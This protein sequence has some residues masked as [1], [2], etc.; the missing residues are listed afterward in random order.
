MD[1]QSL[2]NLFATT[3]NPDPNVQKAGE[4]QIRKISGQEG[5]VTALLQIIAS[6]SVDLAIRQACSVFIKNR[7]QTSYIIDPSRPRPDQLPIAPSDRDAL[8]SSILRLLAASPSRSITVQLASTL[9]NLVAH[10]VP[11]R[12]PGL[13]DEVKGLL[14]SGD[15]REV[16]AGCVAALEIV[17]AFRF[18]QKQD[19]LPSIVEQLMPT[20]VHIASGMMNTPPSTSQEIPTML[21]LIL[22]TYKSSIIVNLSTHQQSG[23]SL[24]PWGR[25]LFQVVNLQIPKEVVPGDEEDRERSEWWKAKKWAYGIL[26]R[27]FHRFGNPSQLPTPMQEEYGPFATHFVTTFAPE[28]FKVYL[29]QVELYVSGQAWLSK[30][31]QYQIFQFFTECVKPKTTWTLLKP[32]FETLVSSFVFPQLSFNSSK[33]QLWENDPVE[34]IRTSVDEYE[35][36]SSPVSAATSFLFS[37]SSNRTKTTFMPILGF[38][39]TVLRSGAAPAQRFGALNMTAALGPFIMR[40]PEV[41]DNMEQFMLQHVLPEFSAPEPYLRAI[42]CEVLGTVVKAGLLWSNEENLNNHSRAVAMALDDPELPVRVQAALALT[43]MIVIHESVKEAV[44]PQVGKV[45][46]DLLKLSD[47]TDL[48]ILNNCMETMVERFQSELLPVAA[49]LTARLCDSYLRLAR[50]SISQEEIDPQTLDSDSLLS[51][52]DDG[53]IYG[54]MGVAK[55]IGTIVAS[56]ES[57]SEILSQIQEIIIP[58]IRFTLEHK[59]LDLF[60]NMYD[61]VDSLTFKLHSISPNMWPVFELTYDLFKSDAVDFLDEMLPTLDNFVSY[62]TDVFK[63]RADYRQKAIDIY[64]TSIVSTQ[65]GENDRVNG[66][67]LAESILLNLRG[68]VDEHLQEFIT[69]ALGC[70]DQGETASFRLAN[71]EVL[72]N[73][74]LYNAS[75]A[76]HL[77]ET[78]KPGTS[79]IFFDNW[80][81]A[82]NSDSRLPRVHD[83]KLS[84]LA[85]C[86]LM[87]LDSSRIPEVLRDGW[88]GIVGGALKIFK[89]LPQAIEKRK[90]LEDSFQEES[91]DDDEED[92]KFL[93]LEGEDEDVWD[94]DSAYLEMLAKEGARLRAKSDR[95]ADG[96]DLSVSS[97]ESEI[98]EELGY[99]SPLDVV[100]PY[101]SFKQALTTFQMQNGPIYQAATTGLNV[102]QQT[103]L[104]EVM[105]IAESQSAADEAQI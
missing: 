61:L 43:E 83:K 38:V 16:G 74:V 63:S 8:K 2:S 71:L 34:Y 105:R 103:L 54:A 91:D 18:R 57:S 14:L 89:D 77:M 50:E 28:I 39:N 36:F 29:Q 64:R 35:N 73:A 85:L 62:G 31:C 1:L 75:A 58:I 80:F 76:L 102:E 87:E 32:H 72:V 104:M 20:L 51:D 53:K 66:C 33:Q 82:I 78:S 69:I 99:F 98:D 17:R 19:I 86:A 22:K 68:Q 24:V 46:Q 25:L 11:D 4:L 26:G 10:D 92:A 23:E 52:A 95:L 47:E 15:I 37:L 6:D 48:D 30:K 27:L 96:D 45:I 56:V 9:K 60:D 79:R 84:I 40:H 5:V 97:E 21:H 101:V 65:L 100:N 7:V 81:V 49:Q 59:I 13:L 12:W 70:L 42:A 44:A 41:K 93:N 94:E 3:Y 67:K 55:T 88:P 90:A